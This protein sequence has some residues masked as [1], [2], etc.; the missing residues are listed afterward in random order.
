MLLLKLILLKKVMKKLLFIL[1]LASFTVISFAQNGKIVIDANGAKS[2][3][4]KDTFDG[5][6]AVFSYGQVDGR[7][8]S[9]EKGVFLPH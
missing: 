7:E 8:I 5:L 9:T 4:V 1:L 6:K 2:E 3:C